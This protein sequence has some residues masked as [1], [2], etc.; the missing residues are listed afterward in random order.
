M[1]TRTAGQGRDQRNYWSHS[2]PAVPKVLSPSPHCSTCPRVS[3]SFRARELPRARAA[4]AKRIGAAL[5]IPTKDVK[6]LIPRTAASLHRAL[7]KPKAVVLLRRPQCRATW[8]SGPRRR[9]TGR[10]KSEAGKDGQQR[11]GEGRKDGGMRGGG[12]EADKPGDRE[13]DRSMRLVVR[14]TRNEHRSSQLLGGNSTGMCV[15]SLTT[16]FPF[17]PPLHPTSPVLQ[18]LNLLPCPHHTTSCPKGRVQQSARPAR[19]RMQC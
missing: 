18:L 1:R 2:V 10:W 5:V 12:G 4:E 7:R 13:G 11:S 8:P 3:G 14:S 19:S 6:M 9:K 15:L 16:F 17:S